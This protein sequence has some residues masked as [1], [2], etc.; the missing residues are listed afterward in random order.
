VLKVIGTENE[1]EIEDGK[2]ERRLGRPLRRWKMLW[3][4][5]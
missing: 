2:P 5:S 3:L 4:K 1:I